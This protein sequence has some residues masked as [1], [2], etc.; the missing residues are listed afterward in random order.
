MSIAV[1]E[2]MKVHKTIRKLTILKQGNVIKGINN[3]AS[4]QIYSQRKKSKYT[5]LYKLFSADFYQIENG[6]TV[7]FKIFSITK[8]K[9]NI[10]NINYKIL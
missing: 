2:E 5:V 8:T 3:M 9:S 4:Q 10:K 7:L 6:F 1:L